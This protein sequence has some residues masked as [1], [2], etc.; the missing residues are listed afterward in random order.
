MS[1]KRPELALAEPGF[2]AVD[3]YDSACMQEFIAGGFIFRMYYGL[4]E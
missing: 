4:T 2:R 3:R 1:D